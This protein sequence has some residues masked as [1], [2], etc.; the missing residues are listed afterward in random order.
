[1]SFGFRTFPDFQHLTEAPIRMTLR[2]NSGTIQKMKFAAPDLDSLLDA[3]A[4]STDLR[5]RAEAHNIAFEERLDR[6]RLDAL[7]KSVPGP[8]LDYKDLRRYLSNFVTTYVEVAE[9][10]VPP[11]FRTENSGASMTQPSPEQKLVRLENVTR[12]LDP[13]NPDLTLAALERSLASTDP[14]EKA[15]LDDFLDQWNRARNNR[16]TFAAFKDQLLFE[17]GD[18]EWPHKLRDRLGLAHYGVAGGPLDVALMEY[19]VEEVLTEAGRSPDIAYPFC[20]PTFLDSRPS[21]RFFPTPKE[22]PAGAP[23]ALFEIWSDEQLI[24]EVLH[25]R[26]TYRRHHIAKLGQIATDGPM[27]DFKSVR[28]NHLAV[29][30]LAAVRDD[31]GEDL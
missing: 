31:F 16:P 1:M 19:T 18:A 8:C 24:A 7:E 12:H 28:N 17:I 23:M 4:T 3:W 30:Q 20:V 6:D 13:A 25:S 26:L 14:A 5:A 29:L 22:L 11:T 9:P 27:A 10:H 15:V 21:S 2:V